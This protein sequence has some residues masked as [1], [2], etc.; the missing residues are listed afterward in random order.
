MDPEKKHKNFIQPQPDA[1]IIA[2]QNAL[3][4]TAGIYYIDDKGSF[5]QD[6]IDKMKSISQGRN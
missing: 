2:A 3:K 6:L 5:R 4:T 1:D